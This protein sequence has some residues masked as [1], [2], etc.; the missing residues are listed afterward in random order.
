M[1][2]PPPGPKLDAKRLL[3]AFGLTPLLSG[4]YPAIFLAEP[5][6]MPI[7]L[8]V[9]Y[10]SALL[11]GLPL[12]MLFDRRYWLTW[13]HFTIGGA[14]CAIPA[15]ILYGHLGHPEHLPHF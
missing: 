6:T 12:I 9:A 2:L 1:M 10:A 5:M 3:T 13:W 11:F 14:A 15:V 8:V 7:G 4:F